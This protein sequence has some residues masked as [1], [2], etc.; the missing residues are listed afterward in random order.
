MLLVARSILWAMILAMF[1]ANSV[2][3]VTTA[4]VGYRF[5]K[6]VAE[7]E[8]HDPTF[9]PP[10]KPLYSVLEQLFPLAAIARYV[11]EARYALTA[12]PLLMLLYLIWTRPQVS[13]LDLAGVVALATITLVAKAY[14]LEILLQITD[15][16][17]GF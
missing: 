11:F 16:S 17:T 9:Y 6:K 2:F 1:V 8:W 12:L 3:D 7:Q 14:L 13:E 4:R 10:V 15:I 5:A